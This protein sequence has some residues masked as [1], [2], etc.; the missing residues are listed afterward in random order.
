MQEWIN[1]LARES[2]ALFVRI[3]KNDQ[4]TEERLTDQSVYFLVKHWI[5]KTGLEGF[6]PHDLRASF[7]SLLSD[8]GEDI[9]TVADCV[10]HSD[11][12][13]TAIYDRR[14]EET[15]S[16][17][18]HVSNSKRFPRFKRYGRSILIKP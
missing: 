13:T 11:I 9:K 1:T 2:G 15:N 3:R 6:S 14:G 10:G 16:V 5:L 7:I 12:R 8:N 4:M 18:Q 17:R